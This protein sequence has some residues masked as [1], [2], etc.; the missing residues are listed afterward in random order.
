M[1]S[2]YIG[3]RVK[4]S[5]SQLGDV[6]GTVSRV[7]ENRIELSQAIINGKGLPIPSLVV[8]SV[9]LFSMHFAFIILSFDIY[10][11]TCGNSHSSL[12]GAYP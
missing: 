12:G 9:F 5:S 2:Q 4:L 6:E 10:C 3:F 7:A 11:Y 1:Q 8:E